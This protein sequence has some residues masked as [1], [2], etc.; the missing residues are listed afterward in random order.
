VV[1]ARP[2]ALGHRSPNSGETAVVWT[3]LVENDG[4]VVTDGRGLAREDLEG[5]GVEP[6]MA[7]M[8]SGR[9]SGVA[10]IRTVEGPVV[11]FF[12]VVLPGTY[13]YYV[14]PDFRTM[15]P[16]AAVYLAG[17]ADAGLYRLVQGGAAWVLLD[18]PL[19]TMEEVRVQVVSERLRLALRDIGPSAALSVAGAGAT[20]LGLAGAAQALLDTFDARVDLGARGVVPGDEFALE[21]PVNVYA[22]YRV[23]SVAGTLVRFAPPAPYRAG[24]WHYTIR[25]GLVSQYQLLRTKVRFEFLRDAFSNLTRLDEVMGRLARGARYSADFAS[26]L[27]EYDEA[28]A[29]MLEHCDAYVVPRDRTVEQAVRV[30]I[31]HGFD[32]AVDFFLGLRLREFFSLDADGV[33]YKTW[34]IRVAADVARRVVPVTKD[35][36]DLMS[37]WRTIAVQPSVRK[38]G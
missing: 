8:L 16:G 29:Q 9:A 20:A 32:R 34:V 31:E 23:E 5:L 33:S 22:E 10:G 35:V 14:G 11:T 1:D 21:G 38:E 19:A 15:Q 36:R 17:S 25:D 13:H 6:G 30:M 28:L 27:I 18:R 2:P 12:G 3:R 4:L 7:I 24:A 37:G 26:T